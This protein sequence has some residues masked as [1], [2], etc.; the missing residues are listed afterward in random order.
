M[1]SISRVTEEELRALLAEL[2]DIAGKQQYI[3]HEEYHLS[4]DHPG[5]PCHPRLVEIRARLEEGTVNDENF[6]DEVQYVAKHIAYVQGHRR[7]VDGHT[8]MIPDTRP[9]PPVPTGL[10]RWWR[11]RRTSVF[12]WVGVQRERLGERIAGREFEDRED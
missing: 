3:I 6:D 5:T 11:Q 10:R 8:G 4:T 1:S 9:T 2:L 12:W 7:T